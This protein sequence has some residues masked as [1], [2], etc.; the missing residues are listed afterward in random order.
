MRGLATFRRTL[1]LLLMIA[2]LANQ[3]L[4]LTASGFIGVWQAEQQ[5]LSFWWQASGWAKTLTALPSRL[6]GQAQSGGVRPETQAD[7]D[8]RAYELKIQPDNVTA[9]PGQQV[10]FQAVAYDFNGNAIPGV[11]FDWSAN[12]EGRKEPATV[13]PQGEFRALMDGTYKVTAYA[14]GRQ[15]QVIV[16]VVGEPFKL[17]KPEE[18]PSGTVST[19][20]LPPAKSDTSLNRSRYQQS[21]IAGTTTQPNTRAT[22]TGRGKLRSKAAAGALTTATA[23]QLWGDTYGWTD[24]NFMTSD[25][26]GKERGNPPG[27]LVDNG[28]GSGNHQFTAPILNLEG[29]GGLDLTLALSYNARVWQKANNEITFDIDRDWPAP[30][31]SLGFGKITQTGLSH[32]F[33]LID[34]DGTRHAF[35]CAYNGTGMKCNTIDGTFIDYEVVTGND[36]I[37]NTPLSA[38]AKMADGTTI[39]YGACGTY[40]IY[41]TKIMDRHGNYITISY[42]NDQGP[43]INQIIDTLGRLV[44]FSYDATNC[45]TAICAP[46]FSTGATRT[47]V[48]LNYSNLTLVHNYTS[49]PMPKVR[50]SSFKMLK[51]IYYPATAT[52][53]WFGDADSYTSSGSSYGMLYKVSE[54]RGMGFDNA[55][56]TS[57]GN[58]TAGT[59]PPSHQMTYLYNSPSTIEPMYTEL[60]ETWDGISQSAGAP[61]VAAGVAKTLYQIIEE[62]GRRGVRIERPGV[63]INVQWQIVAPGQYNDGLFLLEKTCAPAAASCGYDDGGL[64]SSSVNWELYNSLTPANYDS[65]RPSATYVQ[66]APYTAGQQQ[67]TTLTTKIFYAYSTYNRVTEANEFG[68]NGGQAVIRKTKTQYETNSAYDNTARHILRLPKVVEVIEDPNGTN[69][70]KQ[71]T[72]YFYDNG[73]ILS[74]TPNV[75]QHDALCDPQNFNYDPMTDFRGLVTTIKRYPTIGST[76]G[77]VTETRTYDETGNLKTAATSCCEQTT[78]TYNGNMAYAYPTQVTRGSA[79]DPNTQNTTSATYDYYTGLVTGTTDTNGRPSTTNYCTTGVNCTLVSGYVPP[80]GTPGSLRPKEEVSPTGAKVEY[81]YDDTNLQVRTTAYLPDGTTIGSRSLKTLDGIGRVCNEIAYGATL[82][83]DIVQTRYDGL[84]RLWRQT[85]PYRGSETQGWYENTYDPLD[86][87]T[88]VCRLDSTTF[89]PIETLTEKFYDEATVPDATTAAFKGN[90]IRTRDAWNRERWARFDWADRLCEVVEPDA[91]GL[92]DVA[93]GGTLTKYSYDCL[94]NLIQT[95][96]CVVSGVAEQ[97]RKFKYDALSRLTN[98]K[99]AERDCTLNDAGTY[100]GTTTGLWSD[101]FQYDTRSN[102]ICYTDARGVKTNFTYNNDPLNR[103]QS[104]DYNTTGAPNAANI[105]AAAT[106][107]YE[108]MAAGDRTRLKKVTD[109]AGMDEFAYDTEGRLCETKRTFTNRTAFPLTVKYQYDTLDRLEKQTYPTRY[110]MGTEADKQIELTFDEASRVNKLKYDGKD[111]A[112]SFAYNAASQTTALTVGHNLSGGIQWNESYTYEPATGLLSNQKVQAANSATPALDLIYEYTKYGTSVGRTGQLTKIINNKDTSKNKYYDYDALGRL[113]NVYSFTGTANPMTSNQWKQTYGYDR[114]GNRT[115]VTKAGTIA[116]EDGLASLT[117]TDGSN[118]VKTNRITKA[119]YTYD[120]AGNLTCGETGNNVWQK[121]QYDAAGRLACTK[122]N[123]N[124]L[125]ADYTY[126]ASN[127]RLSQTEYTSG[128]GTACF[129]AWDGNTIIAEYAPNGTNGLTWTKSY[130]HLGGRLLATQTAGGLNYHHPDR[131]GTRLV[132]SETGGSVV[133]EQVT[134]PYGTA[135][136]GESMLNTTNRRFTSYDRSQKTKLDYAVNRF[137]S[138]CQGRFT[139]VDP[140]GISAA[141]LDNPQSLNLYAYVGGDPI[142]QTD[143]DGLFWG[144]IGRFFKALGIAILV[145]LGLMAAGQTASINFRTPGFNGNAGL[146]SLSGGGA[147]RPNIFRTPGIN[148]NSVGGVGRFVN[149]GTGSD[150]DWLQWITDAAAGFGDSATFGITDWIREWMGTNRNVNKCSGAYNNTVNRNQAAKAP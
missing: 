139:Q 40:G 69:I 135:L 89:A 108:Y 71:K 41:P 52:G 12:D 62:T 36:P 128:V 131:L 55:P 150:T 43:Q 70:T 4:A 20:D 22:L 6:T 31:F 26:C 61:G 64:R 123:N 82:V 125:L 35:N 8:A 74:D 130:V 116:Y 79:S 13:T 11:K 102:P 38:T 112:T 47:L 103:L 59:L 96:Q 121:Y 95:D 137:Y 143:P 129:Y 134:L 27:R 51:A 106:V 17:R 111:I 110:G 109:G 28:A 149:G 75:V 50:A 88:K 53:Y 67:S 44:T 136:D 16:K 138:S 144:A 91:A 107:N 33:M 21:Q 104:V 124:V 39:T 118:K 146:P 58:I 45:L 15:T 141:S 98:Q 54:R 25:D 24:Q 60:S 147:S 63:S 126:G 72:E 42:V 37:A 140:I 23:L 19:R 87:L 99:L 148:G 92:G 114:F 32:G 80:A 90:T 56:L 127:H 2:L 5:H 145:A 48:R 77:M 122:D 93:T 105:I 117:F 85:R 29:R 9:Q 97:T 73:S 113:K 115:T 46:D 30:G 18:I 78:Y 14:L 133:T 10:I 65:P 132:T 120:E 66:S 86:R 1:S 142:N 83:Q 76:T 94:N 100:V 119:G 7:R 84:G 49:N 81:C 3:A 57:Q 68:F 34:G 101:F